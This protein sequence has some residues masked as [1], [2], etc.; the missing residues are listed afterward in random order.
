M[1]GKS[2]Q[3]STDLK[4]YI[5]PLK[6]LRWKCPSECFKFSTTQ[7]AKP[8]DGILGQKRALEAIDIG[9][10]MNSPGYNIFVAGHTGTGRNSTV[11]TVL[12]KMDKSGYE[13]KDI[14]CVNNFKEPSS[15]RILKLPKSYGNALKKEMKELVSDLKKMIPS[16]LDAQDYK[17]KRDSIVEEYREKQKELFRRLENTIRAESFA[18][19]QVQMGPFTRPMIL[20]LIEN[21]PVQFEQLEN[22]AASGNFPSETLNK[23]KEK[24][25]TLRSTMEETMK[26]VRI[27]ERELRETLSKLDQ[28]R[29]E[30]IV[31]TL[32]S[33][34]KSILKCEPIENYLNEVKSDIVQNLDRFKE[35]DET[36]PPIPMIPGMP[37][38]TED[39][40]F[41]DYEVNVLVDN[42]NTEGRPVI[43]ETTPNYKNLF[44]TIEK[45]INRTGQWITDFTKIR[46][47][48]IVKADGGF[49]VFNL[50]DA[51]TEPGVWKTLKRSL[52]NRQL[53]IESWDAFYFFQI[54]GMKPEP[55]DINVKI[56]VFGEVYLYNLLY[57]LDEDFQKIFKIR[58]DFDSV[59]T[60]DEEMVRRYSS[61]IHKIV[62]DENLMHF[63]RSGVI[64]LVEEGTRRTGTKN[65]LSAR[66]SQLADLV[67]EATYRAKKKKSK[68]VSAKH[69]QEAL[70]YQ[71]LRNN[72]IEEKIQE[73]IE[74]GKILISAEGKSIGQVNGLAV[75]QVGEYAFGKPSRI[76]AQTSMGRAGIVNIE[77][78]SKLSGKI[79]D[80]GVFI[81][82]GYLR[83]RYAQDKPISIS[84]SITFEQNYGGVE[85]DSASS[86]E[87][88]TL[89]SDLAR[90]PLKQEIA[91]TGSVNQKG[92]IQP[93]GGVNEKIEGF[94]D[95]CK[96][97]GLNGRQGVLIPVQN[98]MDLMLNE[99]VVD[100]CKKKQF[101]IY[102][103]STIDE[104]LEVLSD[105]PSGKRGKDGKFPEGT[106]N[107]LV[108][109]RLYDLAI[110][111]KDFGKEDNN[112]E[113]K[114]SKTKAKPEEP[115]KPEK[116]SV[117]KIQ[118]ASRSKRRAA[119][120][121]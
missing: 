81:L 120:K 87:L 74:E 26:Q 86:T 85:G 119:S 55:I 36:S 20:P 41:V 96:A 105:V 29:V 76:T 24:H 59:M 68:L 1:A 97:K 116:K 28:D 34:I 115:P 83:G 44:G 61:F 113:G 4:R 25:Q 8:L 38:Q 110:G 70:D 21:Q 107:Y 17:E 9:L 106:F 79:H 31:V 18:M 114:Q 37:P 47:G 62:T 27:I 69:V 39:D 22:L 108:D 89:L 11:K 3:T 30:E 112:N 92:E 102:Q 53:E 6:E 66:F 75:Y 100:A 84:A 52:K 78:E 12:S 104:G 45:T 95:V 48:S 94:F 19:V 57:S 16:A 60:K 80:K 54:S 40:R 118:A 65:K 13:P 14:V 88:Y 91:V 43:F 121:K 7:D 49:L 98:V 109:K 72:L 10:N 56:I 90:V 42:T 117:K 73:A 58:A 5:V 82:S 67:R 51:I 111:F 101:T 50:M 93:I 64:A 35:K 103:V 33:E 46:S 99:E 2:K 15:P 32:I 77:R 63:D 23:L 71:R